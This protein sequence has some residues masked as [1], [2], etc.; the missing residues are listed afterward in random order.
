MYYVTD[1]QGDNI[2]VVDLETPVYFGDHDNIKYDPKIIQ[3]ELVILISGINGC[4]QSFSL[5][6]E[7]RLRPRR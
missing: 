6:C 2:A 5:S 3:T 7:K 1:W 4:G